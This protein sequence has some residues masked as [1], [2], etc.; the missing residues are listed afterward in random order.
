MRGKGTGGR[1]DSERIDHRI[2]GKGDGLLLKAETPLLMDRER[3]RPWRWREGAEENEDCEEEE[4][5]GGC[6]LMNL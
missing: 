3:E 6:G 4:E 5:E 2:Q 1:N